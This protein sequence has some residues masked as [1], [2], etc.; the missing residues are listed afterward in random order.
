MKLTYFATMRD[1]TGKAGEEWTRPAATLA[2][3]LADLTRAYGAAF[4]E[5]VMEDGV[6]LGPAVVLI[7]GEDARARQG[8]ATALTPGADIIMFPPM[9]GG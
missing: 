6:H 9:S 8:L 2:D 7:D 3:L 1:A 5:S 4:A